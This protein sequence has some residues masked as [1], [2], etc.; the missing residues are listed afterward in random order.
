[1]ARDI[2]WEWDDKL[3]TYY[4]EYIVNL[5]TQ[6]AKEGYLPDVL[7]AVTLNEVE[8]I[9]EAALEAQKDK[10]SYYIK[11]EEIDEW[12]VMTEDIDEKEIKE[13]AKEIAE[14]NDITV[15]EAE[16]QCPDYFMVNAW[17]VELMPIDEFL[18]KAY[19]SKEK[20]GDWHWVSFTFWLPPDGIITVRN[21]AFVS[22][23]MAQLAE[24]IETAINEPDRDINEIAE[25]LD[26]NFETY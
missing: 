3:R 26:Y 10:E 24:I 11:M 21:G 6:N 1:M 25:T 23:T 2:E 9:I 15:K 18:K 22:V 8:N 4:E 14:E 16:E 5:M 20:F 13:I 17:N 12:E 7:E 19:A